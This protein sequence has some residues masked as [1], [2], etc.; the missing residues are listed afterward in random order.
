MRISPG[1]PIRPCSTTWPDNDAADGPSRPGT[2]APRRQQLGPES[3]PDRLLPPGNTSHAGRHRGLGLRSG[4][5]L[6]PHFYAASRESSPNARHPEG[7]RQQQQ[8]QQQ[9]SGNIRTVGEPVQRGLHGQHTERALA[10]RLHPSPPWLGLFWP[11]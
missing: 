3:N 6:K 7:S 9:G 2:H 11:M 4:R 5:S 1:G 10:P 8:Q